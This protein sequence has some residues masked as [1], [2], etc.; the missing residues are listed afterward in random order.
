MNTNDIVSTIVERIQLAEDLQKID[1]EIVGWLNDG[2]K[3][4]S[5]SY[6]PKELVAQI[7][8][9]LDKDGQLINLSKPEIITN[10]NKLRSAFKT[11]PMVELV[12]PFI[13]DRVF[14]EQIS[15]LLKQS[16]QG[17]FIVKFS[18]NIDLIAGAQLGFKGKFKDYSLLKRLNDNQA[19]LFGEVL[20]AY[21]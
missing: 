5:S 12:I 4:I 1:T 21:V 15:S 8:T 20:Q 3:N 10:L 16:I 18:T 19:E 6:L 14:E 11:V 9:V 13:P 7:T 2:A 17:N